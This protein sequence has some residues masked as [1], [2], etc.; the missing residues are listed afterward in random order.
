MPDQNTRF[1]IA[2]QHVRGQIVKLEHSYQSILAN[3]SYTQQVA[4]LLGQALAAVAA[5]GS[6]IKLRGSII[7]QVQGDGAIHTLVAQANNAGE[8]RGLAHGD[9]TVEH[10]NNPL[11]GNG[12]LVMTI[13]AEGSQRYQ[14]IVQIQGEQ[15]S[16][17]LG[18]YFKQS[19]QLPTHIHLA[20]NAQHAACFLLQ[21]LPNGANNVEGESWQHIKILSE[22]LQDEELISLE[23]EQILFR[24][25]HEQTVTIFEPIALKFNCRCS[26]AKIEPVIIQMGYGDAMQLVQEQGEF[27]AQCEF[28]N[29]SHSFD[30]VDVAALFESAQNAPQVKQ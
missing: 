5:L 8:I 11:L 1:L 25:F 12:R 21:Q 3:A 9:Q 20:A 24:L 22:T 29:R 23:V 17:S 7:M 27:K 2:N 26:R 30:Q 15:L 28:C 4:E 6:I 19:E 18:A 16:C 13:E 10:I 14:G